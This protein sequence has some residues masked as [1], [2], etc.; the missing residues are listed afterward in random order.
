MKYLFITNVRP[1][2]IEFHFQKFQSST[3]YSESNIVLVFSGVYESSLES[4]NSTHNISYPLTLSNFARGELAEG[5]KYFKDNQ[6]R[7]YFLEFFEGIKIDL[8]CRE[9]IIILW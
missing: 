7:Y 8:F 1:P 9:A 5:H 2:E 6:I 4:P 3:L